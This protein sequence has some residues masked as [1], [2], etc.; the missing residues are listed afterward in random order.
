[1]K[2]HCFP[3]LFPRQ[4]NGGT[5]ALEARCLQKHLA[6]FSASNKK[7]KHC[8]LHAKNNI[9]VLKQGNIKGNNVSLFARTLQQTQTC[10]KTTTT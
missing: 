5:F 4:A 7:K 9:G 6:T 10:G 1:M 3:K 2:K 8:F